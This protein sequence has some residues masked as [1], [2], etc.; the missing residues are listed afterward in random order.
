[1]NRYRILICTDLEGPAG[2]NLWSQTRE[3]GPAK[4]HAM[5]LLTQEL[6]AAVEGILEA[7]PECEILVTDGHGSGGLLYEE[8]HESVRV[9]MKGI[10]DIPLWEVFSPEKFD[11]FMFVGQHAMAG[12]PNAPL[13]HTFSSRTIEY[14]KLNGELIGETGM[15]AARFGEAGVPTIFLSGDDKSCE[16]VQAIIPGIVTVETKVGTGVQ[17]AIHL[18]APE[19]RRRTREGARRAIQQ[20]RSIQPYRVQ[21]PYCLEIRVLEGVSLEYYLKDGRFTK[22]DERTVT[23]TANTFRELI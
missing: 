6:N 1:M 17:S 16:E 19:S 9:L 22:L 8:V 11:A 3:E 13:N 7:D 5:H 10:L 20:A 4:R 23:R 21:A 2:V 15:H 12:V 18:S 14:Y